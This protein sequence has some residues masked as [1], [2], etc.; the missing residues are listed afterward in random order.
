MAQCHMLRG[1]CQSES[2]AWQGLHGLPTQVSC[3]QASEP[4]IPTGHLH[5]V[6]PGVQTWI[7]CQ[8]STLST[9][10]LPFAHGSSG[11]RAGTPG[12]VR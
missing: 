7:H 10:P 1:L 3:K 5:Q 8:V 11:M 4:F 2:M 6:L 12:Q 9:M